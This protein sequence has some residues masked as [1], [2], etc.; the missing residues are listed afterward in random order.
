MQDAAL[1]GNTLGQFVLDNIGGVVLE[2][3]LLRVN[4]PTRGAKTYAES[5]KTTFQ[6]LGGYYYSNKLNWSLDKAPT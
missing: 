3:I 5:A 2:G 6:R 1:T 4:V